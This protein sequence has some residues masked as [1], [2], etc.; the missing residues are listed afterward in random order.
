VAV[1]RQG[2]EA[3]RTTPRRPRQP[4]TR[5]SARTAWLHPPTGWLSLCAYRRGAGAPGGAAPSAAA[6]GAGAA[7][8]D[9]DDDEVI[10]A[11]VEAE[12]EVEPEMGMDDDDDASQWQ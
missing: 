6:G 1:R 5:A 2:M 9:D 3:V 8:A 10:E 7:A 4:A 12:V 11:E